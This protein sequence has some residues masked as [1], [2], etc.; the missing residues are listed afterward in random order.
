MKVNSD[1]RDTTTR[2][3]YLT[4]LPFRC[5]DGKI[6]RNPVYESTNGKKG[7]EGI[8]KDNLEMEDSMIQIVVMAV[9]VNMDLRLD[10]HKA[11]YGVNTRVML[12]VSLVVMRI[13][14]V[15]KLEG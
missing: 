4:E 3:Q 15:Q 2:R 7:V 14:G 11:G 12:E 1:P 10:T 13:F 9:M 6:G 8:S 5:V